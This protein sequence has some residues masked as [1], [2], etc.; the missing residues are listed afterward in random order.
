M[1]KVLRRVGVRAAILCC[2][3]AGSGVFAQG[4]PGVEAPPTP[5]D[6]LPYGKEFL[7]PGFSNPI[8]QPVPLDGWELNTSTPLIFGHGIRLA[9]QRP[10]V[11]LPENPRNVAFIYDIR[12]DEMRIVSGLPKKYYSVSYASWVGGDPSVILWILVTDETVQDGMRY[13][14]YSIRAASGV[15]SKINVPGVK[16]EDELGL[17]EQSQWILHKSQEQHGGPVTVRLFNLKG[18]IRELN[19]IVPPGSHAVLQDYNAGAGLFVIPEDRKKSEGTVFDLETLQPI[20]SQPWSP[21]V[22]LSSV[23]NTDS[24]DQTSAMLFRGQEKPSIAGLMSM[25][26]GSKKYLDLGFFNGG[27][28]AVTRD[29]KYCVV[30]YNRALFLTEIVRVSKEQ[31]EAIEKQAVIQNALQVGKQV[32]TAFLMYLMDQEKM[33]SKQGFREEVLPYMKSKDMLS[34]F[35]YTGSEDLDLGK[36]S[37]P[38][39]I[40]VG[41]VPAPGGRAVVYADGHVVWVPDK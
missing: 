37:N 6:F 40:E 1:K 9:D 19:S 39:Q 5:V 4:L 8:H 2:L 20:K 30:E 27:Y 38:S 15:A 11:S 13:E 24:T 33:P 14:M 16:P 21:S 34:Q 22:F 35:V 3:F 36:A 28:G 18:E 29:A 10:G 23:G 12:Q 25:A 31:K 41:F 32:G 26:D 7:A 17:S